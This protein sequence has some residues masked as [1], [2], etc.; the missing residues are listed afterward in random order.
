VHTELGG[1]ARNTDE[2]V[3]LIEVRDASWYEEGTIPGAVSV[4]FAGLQDV[5]KDIRKDRMLAITC[6]TGRLSSQAAKLTEDQGERGS[7]SRVGAS[8]SAD[9]APGPRCRHVPP[10]SA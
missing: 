10:G 1:L 7:G 3:L 9:T 5:L 8:L 6:G 2:Q 4:S